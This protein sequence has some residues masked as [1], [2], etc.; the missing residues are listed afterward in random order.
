[1]TIPT[2]GES[3]AKLIEHIRLAQEDS[4][5]LAHLSN[6]NDERQIAIAWLAVS[7]MLKKVQHN[8]TQLATKGLQ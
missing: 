1:M 2:K 3:F 4:A 7:E 6:A 5:T 8:I